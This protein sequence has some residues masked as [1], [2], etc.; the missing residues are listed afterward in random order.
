MRQGSK[1]AE[2]TYTFPP[3]FATF[4]AAMGETSTQR[5]FLAAIE[6]GKGLISNAILALCALTLASCST[7]RQAYV[8]P[9]QLGWQEQQLPIAEPVQTL[10]A[11][12][13]CGELPDEGNQAVYD[14]LANDLV[15]AG[16][17]SAVFYLGDNVYPDGLPKKD[18]KDREE[19]EAILRAQLDI[20]RDF[21]GRVFM[22]PGNHDWNH[23]SSGGRKAVQRQ[24]E[25]VEDYVKKGNSY[26]PDDGCGTPDMV[27]LAGDVVL[28]FLDSQWWLHDQDEEKGM[29]KGCDVKS[30]AHYLE[31]FEDIVLQNRNK[32]LVVVMH[33]PLHSNGNHGGYFGLSQHLFPFTQINH[34]A[35]VP[36]PLLGSVVPIYRKFRG[37]VQDLP[38]PLYQEL[39]DRLAQILAPYNDVI[40]LAGHEHGLQYHPVNGHHYVVSG[41]GAKTEYLR[42]GKTAEYAREAHGYVRIF[43][44]ADG[45]VWLESIVPDA[46]GPVVDYR[47]QLVAPR[48]EAVAELFS[49]EFAPLPDSVTVAASGRYASNSFREWFTGAQYREAWTVP[50]TVP[51]LDLN[52]AYGGL[53]PIQ[54]GGG[55][56][57]NSLLLETAEGRQYALRSVDKDVTKALPEEFRDIVLLNLLQDQISAIHPYSAMVIPTLADAAGI[58][59]TNPQVVYLK[60]QPALGVYNGLFPEGMYLLEER[61]EGWRPDVPSFGEHEEI[62]GY[63][64]VLE[65]LEEDPDHRVDQEFVLR[66]R[67]FDLFIHDWDRGDDQWRWA[68]MDGPDGT[69]IY[70]PIP[71]DRDQTFYRFKGVLPWTV[72]RLG[73]RKFASIHEDLKRP[74]WQSFNARYFDRYFLN[75]PD[76]E[77]WALVAEELQESLTDSVI[78]VALSNWPAAVL[79]ADGERLTRQLQARRDNLERIALRHY[80]YL[81][82]QVSVTGTDGKDYF[83]V[84]RQDNGDTR[85]RVYERSG[86]GKMKDKYYDRTFVR[87]ET[88]EVRLYGLDGD[89]EFMLKGRARKGMTVR[90]I[91]G[92][93]DD[94][95]QDESRV[96]G[97]V[98]R[99]RVYDTPDGVRLS[100]AREIINRSSD[101]LDVNEYDREDF[102]YNSGLPVAYVGYNVDDRIFLGGGYTWT[103]Q[104]FRKDPYWRRHLLVG[105]FA[106]ETQA[107]NLRYRGDFIDA[108]RVLDFYLE[109]EV[110]TPYFINFF[111]LGNETV[112]VDTVRPYHW[113]RIEGA[114]L[115]PF[116]K[117]RLGSDHW[118]IMGGP[119]AERYEIETVEGRFAYLPASGLPAVDFTERY[120]AGAELRARFVSIDNNMLPQEGIVLDMFANHRWAFQRDKAIAPSPLPVEPLPPGDFGQAGG[121]LTFYL[122]IGNRL[123]VTLASRVGLKTNFGDAY[124]FYLANTVGGTEFLRGYRNDRFAGRTAFSQATDL[125]VKLGH[126]NNKILPMDIGLLGGYDYGRVWDEAEDDADLPGAR[127]HHGYTAGLWLAPFSAAALHPFATWSDEEGWLFNFRLGF[128]F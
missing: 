120:Y 32:Q 88:R 76:R 14:V 25:F 121:A 41:S 100:G 96:S 52:K 6:R 111:G 33:H 44:Y 128:S 72:A 39:I 1:V 31:V 113:V 64:D 117:S 116:V 8:A 79:E 51:V 11:I 63:L 71:R 69:K 43:C 67:L 48:P 17:N 12:G 13:D 70:R 91:G 81:S 16:A 54:K 80:D 4:G 46:N 83:E 119:M 84:R 82:R 29:N 50:V 122:T 126:W 94:E 123:P 97:W 61:L 20:A 47:Q 124:P 53:T 24:E 114:S 93:G 75:E 86:K 87:S 102:V 104:N 22:V 74:W 58:Y 42:S 77:T 107:F 35:W 115:R 73:I 37:S 110:H 112:K 101:D 49:G 95:V 26:R 18:A 127:M 106:P 7:V 89:D 62:L 27:K 30:R 10:F 57:S 90:I 36:L 9:E 19:G 45:Q 3:G 105:N 34:D 103:K 66:S 78:Q 65:K 98:R 85:V 59:H 28:I 40:F 118:S 5:S 108:F 92:I 68:R 99:T 55:Q 109:A 125:R 56:A 2:R 60:A 38:H 15:A 21:P 23:W